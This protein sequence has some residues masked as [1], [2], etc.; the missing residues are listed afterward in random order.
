MDLVSSL[1][2][3]KGISLYALMLNPPKKTKKKVIV[4]S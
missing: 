3:S 2:S 4:T 1:N